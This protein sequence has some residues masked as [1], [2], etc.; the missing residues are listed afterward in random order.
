MFGEVVHTVIEL[1]DPTMINL[2][3]VKTNWSCLKI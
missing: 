2:V 1:I 3:I